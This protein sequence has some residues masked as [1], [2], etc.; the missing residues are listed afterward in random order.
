MKTAREVKEEFRQKGLT[1]N[2]WAQQNGFSHMAV[3][4]VISGKT[5]CWYGN[6]HKIAVMLGLKCAE[7]NES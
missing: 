4:R 1:F 5:K 3:H 2:A 7:K 6:G